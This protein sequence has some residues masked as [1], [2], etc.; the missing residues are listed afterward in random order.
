MAHAKG[1]SRPAGDDELRGAQRDPPA[2]DGLRVRSSHAVGGLILV[3]VVFS[4]PGVGLTLQQAALGHDYPL[5]AGASCS[6]SRVLRARRELHHGLRLRRPRPAGAGDL[7]DRARRD[8]R[9]GPASIRAPRRAAGCRLPPGVGCGSCSR[10][11]KSALRHQPPRRDRRSSR[12]LA[13]LLT[14]QNRRRYRRRSPASRPSWKNPSARPTRATD[15][16]AQVIYGG[17][18]SL[19]V[20]LR[21]GGD[22]DGDRDQRS[23][24]SPPTSAAGSTT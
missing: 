22:R 6:C 5:V 2:A 1:L 14:S 17:R 20:A 13:P 4:Y 18:I 10:N 21:G 16:Y 9:S 24:S 8:R 19:V 7:I 23:A 12:S 3:E 11:P 15:V